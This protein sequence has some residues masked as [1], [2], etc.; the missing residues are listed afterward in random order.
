[1]KRWYQL[2]YKEQVG[3]LIGAGALTAFLV[4]AYGVVS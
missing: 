3:Y 2:P 1:M 4:V